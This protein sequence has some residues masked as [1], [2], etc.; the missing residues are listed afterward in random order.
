MIRWKKLLVLRGNGS[1]SLKEFGI[2]YHSVDIT[3]MMVGLIT[4]LLQKP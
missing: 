2:S 4:R 3:D 1:G